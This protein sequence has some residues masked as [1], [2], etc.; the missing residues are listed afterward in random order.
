MQRRPLFLVK[1]T[2]FND[3]PRQYFFGCTHTKSPPTP[4]SLVQGLEPPLWCCL[5][6][7]QKNYSVELVRFQ[8]WLVIIMSDVR[9]VRITRL[10]GTSLQIHPFETIPQPGPLPGYWHRQEK[11][12]DRLKHEPQKSWECTPKKFWNL[13]TLKRYFGY[14]HKVFLP[15]NQSRLTG[16]YFSNW[17]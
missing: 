7:D 1:N 17:K 12:C 6:K 9:Y 4:H 13:G 11:I 5:T 10:E 2:F 16:D 3:C 15:K 14:F 8:M